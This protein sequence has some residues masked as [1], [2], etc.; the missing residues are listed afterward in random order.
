MG[1]IKEEFVANGAPYNTVDGHKQTLECVP[2]PLTVRDPIISRP[3]F[4]WFICWWFWGLLIWFMT[5]HGIWAKMS[6]NP[7][8]HR[9]ILRPPPKRSTCRPTS[10]DRESPIK[11]GK[12]W[13]PG[14]LKF[15][16]SICVDL[17]HVSE[18][19]SDSEGSSLSYLLAH[20][21]YWF[22]FPLISL[23]CSSVPW[24]ASSIVLQPPLWK[25]KFCLEERS[26]LFLAF[27]RWKTLGKGCWQVIPDS[28]PGYAGNSCQQLLFGFFPPT[29]RKKTA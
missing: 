19:H 1:P 12:C 21:I 28:G 13:T 29:K 25:I 2:W 11:I 10:I 24:P 20:H 8:W 27:C 26:R 7:T 18:P 16:I 15:L 22:L 17:S 3:F 4:G 14:S 9:R 5:L 6:G 23:E